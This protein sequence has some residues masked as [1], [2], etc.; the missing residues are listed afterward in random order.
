MVAMLHAF[1]FMLWYQ[2]I[3]IFGKGSSAAKVSALVEASE[4]HIGNRFHYSLRVSLRKVQQLLHK[5]V[6]YK[7]I[8]PNTWS[9]H[10]CRHIYLFYTYEFRRISPYYCVDKLLSITI[11][12]LISNFQSSYCT[13][14][15]TLR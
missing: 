9:S 7:S 4:R 15:K 1:D 10:A 2:D 11:L 13:D 14:L 12:Q 8:L 5:Y 3:R 6:D